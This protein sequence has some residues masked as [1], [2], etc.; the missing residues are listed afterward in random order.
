MASTKHKG[1]P[2]K[3]KSES[4]SIDRLKE[5]IREEFTKAI[6][7]GPSVDKVKKDLIKTIDALKK[8]F[9]MYKA[10]KEAGDEK[11]LDKHRKIALNLTKKKKDLELLT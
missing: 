8:N 5:I 1:L 7:E 6:N 2:K 3:V 10:A 4:I 11:K 9:P